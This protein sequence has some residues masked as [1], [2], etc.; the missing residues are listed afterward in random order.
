MTTSPIAIIDAMSL[1]E[2]QATVDQIN[3]HAAQIG[4]LLLNLRD[5]EGWRALGYESWT[6]CLEREFS[7]SRKHLYELMRATPVQE[8]VLPLGYNL[9]TAQANEL[10][11]YPQDLQVPI[12][13]A[14]MKRYGQVTESRL[15]RVGEVLTQAV[16]T[17]YT[18]TGDGSTSTAIDASLNLEDEEARKRQQQYKHQNDTEPVL[19][20]LA[21][22][23][24]D[25]RRTRERLERTQI[26]YFKTL[27]QAILEM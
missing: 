3:S 16:K 18:S 22:Y 24:D 4:K 19:I 13:E 8:R 25:V 14:T 5:R 6:Q 7:F 17:G 15:R 12:V 2:A 1:D 23:P 9:N 27:Q 21:I 20:T 11:R 26:P 10:S